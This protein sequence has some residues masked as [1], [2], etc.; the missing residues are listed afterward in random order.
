MSNQFSRF[1]NK[2]CRV[3]CDAGNGKT[4]VYN[5]IVLDIDDDYLTLDDKKLG[6]TLLAVSDI[7][8]VNEGINGQI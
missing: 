3:F 4:F 5:G 2:A 6:Q 1:L 7:K 8:Q